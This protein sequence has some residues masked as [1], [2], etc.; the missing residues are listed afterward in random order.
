[1]TN[2]PETGT[3]KRV[4]LPADAFLGHTVAGEPVRLWTRRAY[5]SERIE[6]FLEIGHQHYQLDHIDP[7]LAQALRASL[8]PAGTA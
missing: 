4:R 6:V 8:T 2:A 7:H 3:A 5:S 1:M